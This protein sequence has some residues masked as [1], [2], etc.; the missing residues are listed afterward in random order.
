M[1][2]INGQDRICIVS[3]S[4]RPLWSAGPC[5]TGKSGLLCVGCLPRS[6]NGGTTQTRREQRVCDSFI[7]SLP[8]LHALLCHLPILSIRVPRSGLRRRLSLYTSQSPSRPRSFPHAFP[9]FFS[10]P[11]TSVRL[12]V[13]SCDAL[14]PGVWFILAVLARHTVQWDYADTTR[15]E[16]L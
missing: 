5:H 13:Q 14:P 16:G 12:R 8:P 11:P 10:L 4:R 6:T 9:F 2:R 7:W 1:R 3:R 15:A